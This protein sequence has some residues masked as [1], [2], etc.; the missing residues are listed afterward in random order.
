MDNASEYGR[1]TPRLAWL[2][3]APHTWAAS[4]LPVLMAVAFSVAQGFAISVTLALT[5]LAISILLQSAVN[6]MNDYFD[7][8]RGADS[9]ADNVEVDDAVL[10]YNK[11]NPKSARNLAVAFVAV[12]LGLG[13]YCIAC[14]GWVPLAVALVGVVVVFLYSGGA[15]PLSYLPVGEAVSGIVMG[16]LITFASSVVLTRQVEWVVIAWSAPLAIGIALIMLTNN[17]CDIEKDAAARRRT[18]PTMIGRASARRL[19]RVLVVAWY[20]CVITVVAAWFTPGVLLA[21]F[22]VLATYPLAKALFNNPLLPTS[23][24]AG[25]SAICSMNVAMGAFFAAMV[26]ASAA[27]L[28]L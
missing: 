11:I 3:A 12:A 6:T 10:V 23:R 19:Y 14:A 24:I 18:L 5:L 21:P 7:Y 27:T 1:L 26:L 22:L 15:K 2:L 25:M 9:A 20:V 8:V 13:V 17:A 28:S 16:V 4:I